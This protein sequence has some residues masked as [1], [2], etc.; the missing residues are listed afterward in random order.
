MVNIKNT[1]SFNE[2]SAI[3]NKVVGDCFPDDVYT[4]ANYEI[5]FRVA[6]LLAFAP[7]Y[8]FQNFQNCKTNN[9]LWEKV[10]N[11]EANEI[12]ALIKQDNVYHC[13]KEAIEKEID[14]RIKMITSSPMSMAD[15]ALS[16]FIDVITNKVESANLPE[17]SQENIDIFTKAATE[18]NGA[19][20]AENLVDTMLDKGLL[21]KPNRE[22]RRKNSK[23]AKITKMNV[24]VESDK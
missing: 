10:A 8:S 13:I 2:Y 9:E 19:N 17:F 7:E 11:K 6:L 16:K 5:S 24:E 20:F 12:L 1:I 23:T 3:I 15:M 21:T 22:N 14:Y 18:L 4:P